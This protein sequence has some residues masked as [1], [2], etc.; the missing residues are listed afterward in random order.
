MFQVYAANRGDGP[1]RYTVEAGKQLSDYWSAAR[2]T[3]GVY[4]LEAHGP[5][6]FLRQ[7]GGSV[8]TG[9]GAAPEVA[10]S[11]DTAGNRL[12]LNLSNNG[13]AA[14]TV[15]VGNAYVEGDVR[16]YALAA[17]ATVQDSWVLDGNANWYDLSVT[18]AELDGFWRRLAGHMEN[19]LPSTSEP[20]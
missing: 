17:G 10:A 2:Y 11:Y 18:V 7:Y 4:D 13:G 1:W 15:T 6:G 19:G 8:A 3:Q 14:C 20:R 9:M 5:N 16:I 12:R